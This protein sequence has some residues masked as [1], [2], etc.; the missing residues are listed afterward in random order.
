VSA[1][2]HWLEEEG[3][4]T[5]LI[6]LFRPHA[7]KVRPP[8]ALWVPFELGRP[9]G[10]PNDAAF[11]RRVLE[12]AL[13]LLESD[14]GPGLL[15]DF[16]D[17]DPDAAGDAGWICPVDVDAAGL[18]AEIAQVKPHHERAVARFGRTTV[19]LAGVDIE[20]AGAYLQAY[21]VDEKA[22]R[23][24]AGM[25]PASLMRF[26]ADDIKAF[27][28]EAAGAGQGRPSS[29]QLTDWFWHRTLAGKVIKDI[30]RASAGSSDRQRQ[31][32]GTKSIVPGL[33]Q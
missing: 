5:T 16:P 26:C 10:P 1:L 2:A 31:V 14:A 22:E 13:R 28:L 20:Q 4:A 7:E 3:V 32:L 9:L 29:R 15:V 8:R 11:Q 19:G 6:A 21:A 23:P 25:A 24:R 30:F 17:D 12:Q 27:Y 18:V 33:Y